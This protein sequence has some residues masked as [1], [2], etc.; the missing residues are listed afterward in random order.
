MANVVSTILVKILGDAK[1]LTGALT[2]ADAGLGGTLKKV[3][4]GL[5]ALGGVKAGFD[6]LGDATTEFDRLED[7]TSRLNLQLGKLSDPLI[8]A[9]DNFT[10][11]GLSKQD[12]LELAANF[13]DLGTKAGI[14]D[15]LIASTADDVAAIAAAASLLGDQDAATIV[16]L[17]GK[18]AGGATK[19]LGELGV[20]LNETE[21]TARAL[22]DTG[23]DSATAL[24]DNELAAARLEI[25]LEQLQPKLDEVANSTGDVEGKQREL[26][27]RVETLSAQLGKELAPVQEKVLGFLLDEIDAIPHAIDGFG[28]LGDAIVDFAGEVLSPLAR[29]RDALDEINRLL[30]QTGVTGPAATAAANRAATRDSQINGANDRNADRNGIVRDR[31]GGP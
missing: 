23:K 24:S 7:A 10:D 14:A 26:G 31:I 29:V 6:A 11:L 22:A 1:G 5:I 12:V 9:A 27:A 20:N 4:V 30:G 21:V 28:M 17:I 25:I 18:A 19:P 13:A 8:D 2:Q 15:P 16:D 3:G